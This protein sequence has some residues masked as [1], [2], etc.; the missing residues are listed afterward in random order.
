MANS[1]EVRGSNAMADTR[2]R[3][4]TIEATT[5]PEE[6][7]VRVAAYCRVSTDSLDQMNSFAAQMKYYMELITGKS[8]WKLVDIYADPGVTGTSAKKRKDFQRLLTDCRRGKI[9]RVLVKS[10]SRFAR[11]TKECLEIVRELKAIGVAVVFEEQHTGARGFP[12]IIEE[13][14]LKK[15]AAIR[16]EKVAV[17]PKSRAERAL[18]EM[19]GSRV[20]TGTEKRVLSMLNQ[21]MRNPELLIEPGRADNRDRDV[22]ETLLTSFEEQLEQPEVDCAAAS[23]TA[24]EIAAE[25]YAEIGDGEYETERLRRLLGNS[26]PMRELDELIL[27]TTVTDISVSGSGAIALT[28]RNGQIYE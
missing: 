2:N 18:R 23:Q 12:P 26:E 8:N 27:R 21:L 9:D 13:E 1:G 20:P 17:R 10:I 11:N 25:Q 15:A 3:V 16:G 5:R 28:L 6:I 19:L 4:I 14:Q 22:S 24:M 7:A